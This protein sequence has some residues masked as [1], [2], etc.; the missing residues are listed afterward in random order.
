MI[1][2]IGHNLRILRFKKNL[3]QSQAAQGLGISVN[4]LGK[5]ENN[6]C[7]PQ[8]EFIQKAAKFYE[9]GIEDILIGENL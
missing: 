6:K 2:T 8:K 3:T 1:N 4:T 7:F 5:Y 9:V